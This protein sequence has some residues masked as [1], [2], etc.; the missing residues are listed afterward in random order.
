MEQL[1]ASSADARGRYDLVAWL[2]L[3]ALAL[4]YLVAFASLGFQITAL[5]GSE[6]IY[7]ISESLA[8]A[9]GLYGADAWWRLPTLFW[10]FDGDWALT[11]ACLAGA[12]FSLYLL[13]SRRERF[14]LIAL[15]VLYLSLSAA[16]RVFLH[17]QWDYLLL[18]AGFLAIFLPGG[19]RIVVWLFRWLLI[20]LRLLSGLAKLASGDA[21]WREFT[22]LNHYFETHPLPPPGSRTSCRNGCCASAPGRR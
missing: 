22:A 16:G 6:G 4:I 7:P 10:I 17:F 3:R 12:V 13:F 2:F 18:E 19:N 9:R 1:N 8:E 14:A 21:G 11:G 20:R 15:F 5:A